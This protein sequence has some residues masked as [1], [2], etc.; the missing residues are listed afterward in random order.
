MQFLHPSYAVEGMPVCGNGDGDG[1]LLL[2][3]TQLAVV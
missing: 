1:S 3:V 2:N